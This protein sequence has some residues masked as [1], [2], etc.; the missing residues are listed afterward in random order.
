ML[1]KQLLKFVL[2]ERVPVRVWTQEDLP[3]RVGFHLV[4]K[5]TETRIVDNFLP[6]LLLLGDGRWHGFAPF[7]AGI[8][9]ALRWTIRLAAPLDGFSRCWMK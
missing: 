9:V 7:D 4:W 6:A 1:A 8:R 5:L 2:V 3:L